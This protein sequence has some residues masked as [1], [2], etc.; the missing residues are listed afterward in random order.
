[1]SILGLFYDGIGNE[2]GVEMALAEANKLSYAAAAA[3]V[4]AIKDEEEAKLKAEQEEL[5]KAL[6]QETP[7]VVEGEQQDQAQS[8]EEVKGQTHGVIRT[9]N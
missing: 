3:A 7:C 5:N 4:K 1:M 8:P 6:Q 2:I 9:F